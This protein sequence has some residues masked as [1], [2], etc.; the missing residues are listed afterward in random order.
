[1]APAECVARKWGNS[2]GII[3]PKE[4]IKQQNIEENQKIIVEFRKKHTVKE[5]FGLLPGWKKS[6]SELKREM[7][8]GWE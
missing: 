4:I 6:T 3:I 5:F 2:I 8:E 1:M 7:K